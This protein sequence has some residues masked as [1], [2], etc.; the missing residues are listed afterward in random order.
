MSNKLPPKGKVCLI[1]KEVFYGRS[2]AKTCSSVCRKRLQ[3]KRL[4]ELEK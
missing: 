4:K 1:C 2:D 3:Y